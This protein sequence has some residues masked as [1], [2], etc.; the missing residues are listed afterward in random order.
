MTT[1]QD[2]L[3]VGIDIGGTHSDGALLAGTRLLAAA[4]TPT[5]H[6]EL[7]GSITTLLGRLLA[8]RDAEFRKKFGRINLSTTL[9]T[10]AIVSVPPVGV[11]AG[12]NVEKMVVF[13]CSTPRTCSA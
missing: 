3:A 6:D 9:A 11:P 8:D 12:V 2:D 7:L 10:N 4:K 1:S 13:C 5:R